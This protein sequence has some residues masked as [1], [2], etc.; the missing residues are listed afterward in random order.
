MG[1]QALWVLLAKLAQPQ[2]EQDP[3]GRVETVQMAAALLVV[4]VVQMVVPVVEI[5]AVVQAAAMAAV[6]VGVMVAAEV[7]ATEVAAKPKAVCPLISDACTQAA[8]LMPL[9]DSQ[10]LAATRLAATHAC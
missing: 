3:E 2:A 5:V 7:A 9:V 10:A 1:V 8:C 4:P 6:L